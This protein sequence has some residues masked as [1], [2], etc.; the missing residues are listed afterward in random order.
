MNVAASAIGESDTTKFSLNHPKWC[1]NV[2]DLVHF[3]IMQQLKVNID[4]IGLSELKWLI[5]SHCFCNTLKSDILKVSK[6]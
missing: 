6:L 2:H 1:G 5:M 4:I 3:F